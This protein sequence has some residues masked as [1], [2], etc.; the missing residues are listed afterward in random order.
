MHIGKKGGNRMLKSNKSQA[1]LEFLMTYGWAILVVLVV[2]SA[3]AYFGV[4]NPQ[5][6]LPPRC[7]FPSGISCASAVVKQGSNQI[8]LRLVNG[9]GG[10]I[11]ISNITAVPGVGNSLGFNCT[12]AAGPGWGTISNVYHMANGEAG[13]YTLNCGAIPSTMVNPDLKYRWALVV[14]YYDDTA[15]AAYATTM[16]GEL[17]RPVDK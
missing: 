13:D 11:I 14:T 12:A 15:T 1:A 8:N 9:G 10:G 16:S 3:L 2:I 4:M 5:R 7:V 6:Y 17:Y